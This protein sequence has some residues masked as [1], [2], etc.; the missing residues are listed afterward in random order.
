MTKAKKT[1]A[2]LLRETVEL[3]SMLASNYHFASREIS[4]AKNLLGSGV[5]LTLTGLGGNRIIDPVCILDGLSTE[6]VDAL[7]KDFVRSY[8]LATM[9]KP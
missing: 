4:K 5:V 3:R 2:D 8:E 1:R 7:L 6:T 9:Y